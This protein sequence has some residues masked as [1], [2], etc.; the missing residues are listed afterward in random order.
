VPQAGSA[1]IRR[2][3]ETAER[4]G[5]KSP[6]YPVSQ[7]RQRPTVGRAINA[8]HVACVNGRLGTPDCPVC[9]GQCSVRQPIP[10]TNGRLHPIWKEIVHR[11]ATVAI[12][13]CT[14]LSGAPLDRRQELPTKLMTNG[15]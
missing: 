14:R 2:S 15:S 1:P 6:D 10:R 12:R 7:L 4:R 9:I 13:W 11:T 5:Y 8:R 3:W